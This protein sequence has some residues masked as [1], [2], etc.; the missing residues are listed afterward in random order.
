MLGWQ[1]PFKVHKVCI[2]LCATCPTCHYLKGQS[3]TI[4]DPHLFHHSNLPGQFNFFF[5]KDFAELFKFFRVSYCAESISPQYHSAC[6]ESISP[7]YHTVQT[8]QSQSPGTI[9][10]RQVMELF[11]VYLKEQSYNFSTGFFLLH[12]L[13]L[14]YHSAC[15]HSWLQRFLNTFAE[16]FNPNPPGP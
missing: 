4:F 14:R 15:S 3:N 11:W 7:H 1:H 13:S 10:P 2:I 6:A 16:A 12:N 8:A 5:S 9:I